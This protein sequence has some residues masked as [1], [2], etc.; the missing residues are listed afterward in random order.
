MAS[1]FQ[2]LLPKEALAKNKRR[3]LWV[4]LPI[5]LVCI[6][7]LLRSLDLSLFWQSLRTLSMSAVLLALLILQM[8]TFTIA[9]RWQFILQSLTL[10][11]SWWFCFWNQ[12]IAFFL[13]S[14]LPARL[15]EAYRL[16]DLKKNL[17]ISVGS[18][19]G[20][21]G[22]EK[23]SDFIALFVVLMGMSP[24][25]VRDHPLPVLKIMGLF[26]SGLVGLWLVLMWGGSLDGDKRGQW[27]AEFSQKISAGLKTLLHPKYRGLIFMSAVSHWL[28][29]SLALWTL[30]QGFGMPLQFAE[31]CFVVGGISLA[32][33]LP[34]A[35]GNLGTFEA[36]AVA[37]LQFFGHSFTT[38]LALALTY[39]LMQLIPTLL[40][41]W[42]GMARGAKAQ[43]T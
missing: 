6:V 42:L 21:I 38:S 23:L 20:A 12:R 41:G 8:Q 5:S 30:A 9:F 25:L 35:P 24:L 43:G 26:V 14:L 28:F 18:G 17:K 2:A 40:I 31:A 27:I 13:N 29:H 4:G 11:V 36:G 10:K 34:A 39:H 22:A 16:Y 15:G 19:L 37:V 32:V 7:W 3:F 1:G 33:A